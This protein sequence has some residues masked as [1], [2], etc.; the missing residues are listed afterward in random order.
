MRELARIVTQYRS[1]VIDDGWDFPYE[2]IEEIEYRIAEVWK[3][4]YRRV[5]E[6]HNRH[7]G[8]LTTEVA[9]KYATKSW[10]Y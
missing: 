6:E 5:C 10:I 7:K 9:M 3:D 1:Y 4:A 2:V 8:G